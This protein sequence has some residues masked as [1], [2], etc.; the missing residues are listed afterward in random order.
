MDL[1]RPGQAIAISRSS[2]LVSEAGVSGGVS[3]RDFPLWV[4]FLGGSNPPSPPVPY[5][6]TCRDSPCQTATSSSVHAGLLH[7]QAVSKRRVLMAIARGASLD[8]IP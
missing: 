6:L 1:G 4:N 3:R 7:P 2:G 5:S 8:Y